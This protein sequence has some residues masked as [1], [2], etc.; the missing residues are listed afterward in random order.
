LWNTE[1]GFGFIL[2]SDGGKDIFCHY[3]SIEDGSALDK[4]SIVQFVKA[5][6]KKGKFEARDVTGGVSLEPQPLNDE[7]ELNNRQLTKEEFGAERRATWAAVCAQ[8]GWWSP[9]VREIHA[10][11]QA[12]AKI[13]AGSE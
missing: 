11:A 6:S 9:A 13:P 3:S 12:Q 1:K 8:L 7:E 5:I 2:P 10:E 4:G